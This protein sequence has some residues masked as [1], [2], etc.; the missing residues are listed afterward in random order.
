MKGC[1]W[2]LLSLVTKMGVN[3]FLFVISIIV[4]CR[5]YDPKYTAMLL[6]LFLHNDLNQLIA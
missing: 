3:L 5:V 4:A 1:K 6:I 2:K